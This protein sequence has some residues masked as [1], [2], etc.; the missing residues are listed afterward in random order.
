MVDIIDRA[1]LV[2]QDYP[3]VRETASKPEEMAVHVYI[4]QSEWA[5]KF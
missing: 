3:G 2:V 1:L 5:E 4:E